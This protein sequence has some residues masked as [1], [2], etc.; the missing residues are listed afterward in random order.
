MSDAPTPQEEARS[1]VAFVQMLEGGCL[2]ADLTE[3]LRDLNAEMNNHAQAFGGDPKGKLVLTIDFAL[4]KGTFDITADYKVTK[5]KAKRERS[6]AWSTPANNF[7]PDN[8]RQMTLF[9]RP[10]DVTGGESREVRSV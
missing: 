10:R 6:I 7:S 8:P 2:N 3:A 9:G 5:P 4:T 1:F